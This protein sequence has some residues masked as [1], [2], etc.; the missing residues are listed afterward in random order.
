MVKWCVP[1]T[2]Y[3]RHDYCGSPGVEE[4]IVYVAMH[5]DGSQVT[6]TPAEF[7]QQFGWKNDPEKA[8]L[9][10]LEE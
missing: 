9:L 4:H 5:D 10:K 3:T 6:C 8:T 7:A 1:K 2:P